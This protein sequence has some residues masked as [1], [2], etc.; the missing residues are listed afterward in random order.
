MALEEAAN[1]TLGKCYRK[2]EEK[3]SLLCSGREFSNSI[4]CKVESV[5][6]KPRDLAKEMSRQCL[7]APWF[8]SAAYIKVQEG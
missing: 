4:T 8:L 6:K 1:R 7:N 2:P 3:G 5:P